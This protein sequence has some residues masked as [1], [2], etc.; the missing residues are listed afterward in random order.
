MR[1]HDD[2]EIVDC[3]IHTQ[4]GKDR[5]E[6]S[7]ILRGP[8]GPRSHEHRYEFVVCEW[9]PSVGRTRTEITA[10]QFVAE[11]EALPVD[12]IQIVARDWPTDVLDDILL[13]VVRTEHGIPERYAYPVYGPP[14]AL[15]ERGRV[16]RRMLKEAEDDWVPLSQRMR[17]ALRRAETPVTTEKLLEK[18]VGWTTESPGRGK[19]GDGPAPGH[20]ERLSVPWMADMLATSEETVCAAMPRGCTTAGQAYDLA[21]EEAYEAIS[22]CLLSEV[23]DGDPDATETVVWRLVSLL[24]KRSWM[25][26]VVSR[27]PQMRARLLCLVDDRIGAAPS[28]EGASDAEEREARRR[29]LYAIDMAEAYLENRINL[30]SEWIAVEECMKILRES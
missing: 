1:R 15:E 8:T 18:V 14:W 23:P 21:K 16:T 27:D 29:R 5:S 26:D 25:C 2:V 17:A 11:L 24:G 13:H 22:S 10:E 4:Y 20:P 6:H 12:R 9:D 7:I 3:E 19:E 30:L 28:D